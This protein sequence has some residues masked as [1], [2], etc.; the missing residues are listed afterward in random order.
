VRS[1]GYFTTVGK[2]TWGQCSTYLVGS[3]RT[4]AGLLIEQV[5]FV[6]AARRARLR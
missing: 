1:E 2:R 4:G 3:H 6:E 5:I